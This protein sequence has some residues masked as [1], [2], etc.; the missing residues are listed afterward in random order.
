MKNLMLIGV[1]A[2]ALATTARAQDTK[3]KTD[4]KIKADDA[5]VMTLT[6][7]LRRDPASGAFMLF[8]TAVAGDE[9]RTKTTTSTDVDRNEKTVTTKSKTK[10]DDGK[11][12]SSFVVFPRENVDLAAHVGHEVQLAAVIVKLG[13][14]DADVKIEQKTRTDP[15]HGRDTT[16]RSTTKLELPRSAAGQYAVVDVKP[17]SDTCT[18]R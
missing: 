15:E 13:H 4:T 7:C 16:S 3:V 12:M 18:A 14:G 9:L 2:V 11:A 5:Q 8:G 17:I 6:G 1:A 10:V